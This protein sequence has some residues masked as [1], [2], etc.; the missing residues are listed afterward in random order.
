MLT[1]VYQPPVPLTSKN[2]LIKVNRDTRKVIVSKFTEEK[3]GRVKVEVSS[4]HKTL[5]QLLRSKPKQTKAKN[6]HLYNSP[7]S[8]NN[9]NSSNN[10]NNNNNEDA[11]E[12]AYSSDSEPVR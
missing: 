9:K 11:W 4:T 3:G 6:H 2:C 5:N 10:L 7:S 12:S 1:C 8:V